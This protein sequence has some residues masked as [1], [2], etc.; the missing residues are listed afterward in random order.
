[1]QKKHHQHVLPSTT[2]HSCFSNIR[3]GHISSLKLYFN[4][5]T[6]KPKACNTWWK[7]PINCWKTNF[8][9]FFKQ[10]WE[11]AKVTL[12]KTGLWK[13]CLFPLEQ[14]AIDTSR[15]SDNL[16]NPPPSSSNL[17]NPNPP[18]SAEKIASLITVLI[19]PKKLVTEVQVPQPQS[20]V[21]HQIL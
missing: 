11:S 16:S 5:I 20:T 3:R 8:T 18:T 6:Q 19:L 2:Y 9:K 7:E 4:R 14:N 12:I 17:S 1:M 13:C 15:I 10:P 21:S